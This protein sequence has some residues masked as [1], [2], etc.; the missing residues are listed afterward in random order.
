MGDQKQH[1]DVF[2]LQ[3]SPVLL[4]HMA[5]AAVQDENRPFV[6]RSEASSEG[7]ARRLDVRDEDAL[8]PLLENITRDVA[9][10]SGENVTFS[11]LYPDSKM[12]VFGV[13][14]LVMRAGLSLE[15]LRAMHTTSV[16][17]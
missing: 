17:R 11:G 14:F 3:Q 8:Q 4:V 5:G 13:L 6:K 7:L 16:H 10:F 9:I 12:R 2:G 1:R 15:P